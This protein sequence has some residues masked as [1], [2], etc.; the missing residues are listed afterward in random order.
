MK[1]LRLSTEF[2]N[3]YVWGGADQTYAVLRKSRP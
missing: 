3:I 2:Q 1:S